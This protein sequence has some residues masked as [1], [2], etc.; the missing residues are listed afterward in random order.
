MIPRH[1]LG[2]P[3]RAGVPGAGRA[4]PGAG[5]PTSTS[6]FG[7]G[8]HYLRGRAAGP[9]GGARRAFLALLERFPE[10]EAG[11]PEGP[12]PLAKVDSRLRGLQALPLELGLSRRCVQLSSSLRCRLVLPL[13]LVPGGAQPALV[14]GLLGVGRLSPPAPGTPRSAG[15]LPSVT[16]TE[17]SLSRRK[18][19]RVTASPRGA[20]PSVRWTSAEPS[21]RYPS[22]AST[23]SSGYTPAC[24]AGGA[25]Q[26]RWRSRSGPLVVT[27]SHPRGA[28][29]VPL[30]PRRRPRPLSPADSRTPGS[31]PPAP[32]ERR[33]NSPA[34]PWTR[35]APV[36]EPGHLSARRPPPAARL[37]RRSSGTPRLVAVPGPEQPH[38]VRPGRASSEVARRSSRSSS[39]ATSS[40]FR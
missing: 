24:I 9:A 6:P 37:H 36:E 30:P 3:R 21:T 19:V 31:A 1:R 38:H 4:G 35:S 15:L 22:S 8:A 12:A 7:F 14:G 17:S 25:V 20:S 27:P 13:R 40:P 10:G 33:P 23:S 39:S 16:G 28:Q 18:R 5:R 29:L 32:R 11:D 2:Q 26:Q 34:P